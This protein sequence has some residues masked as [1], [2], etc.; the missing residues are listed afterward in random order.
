LFK[1]ALQALLLSWAAIDVSAA[2]AAA[3]DQQPPAAQVAA[4]ASTA[5]FG[6]PAP[7]PATGQV[8]DFSRGD[9]TMEAPSIG[10]NAEL[11]GA[12]MRKAVEDIVAFSLASRDAGDA[13]WGRIA[14]SPWAA[15]TVDYVEDRFRKIGL[16]GV[17]RVAVPFAGPQALATKWTVSVIGAPEF[18]AGSADIVLRS[19]FPMDSRPEGQPDT[20]SSA[21]TPPRTSV[22]APVVYLGNGTQAEIA[23]QDVRGKIAIMRVE[24]SPGVFFTPAFR[25]TQQLVTAGA[26]GVLLIYDAPGNMQTHFGTCVGAPCFTLGG[27]DGEFLNALIA[28]AAKARALDKL[29]INLSVDIEKKTNQTGQILFAKVPGRSSAENLIISAHSDAWFT[30]ANDNASGMAVLMALAEHYA[31]GPKPAHDLY[32]VLSPGHHSP[33]GSLKKFI[34]LNPTVPTSNILTINLEHVGQQ[35]TVRSYFSN[36]GAMGPSV[37]KYGLPSN[38]WEPANSDSL[39]REI[40]VSPLTPGLTALIAQASQRTGFAAPRQIRLGTPGETQAIVAAGATGM[41]TVETSIWYHTSG[42]T[43]ET[44][45]PETLQRSALFFKDIIDHADQ[46][47]R[48]RLR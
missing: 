4:P 40:S 17:T 33:T 5:W 41:Q 46:L 20:P 44:V 12:K 31:K 22:T 18:G 16:T 42:D 30:G 10:R 38:R 14:D 24:P 23:L 19:A 34:E 36:T 39:G 47:S 25:V 6:L 11:S 37:S 48:A 43:P 35:A 3:R 13:N 45:A 2:E 21:A 27:E 1:S 26:A 8:L 28:R 7:G 32:F 9:L 29:R 15:K